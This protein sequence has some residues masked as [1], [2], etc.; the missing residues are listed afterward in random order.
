[1]P[2]F[3]RCRASR[4]SLPNMGSSHS[5]ASAL[6]PGTTT[7][8]VVVRRSLDPP[9]AREWPPACVENVW[10]CGTQ[11]AILGTPGAILV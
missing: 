9:V 7:L 1:M 5:A 6:P 2:R 3:V 8:G 4:C 11:G 10:A